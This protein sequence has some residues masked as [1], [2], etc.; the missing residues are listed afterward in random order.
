MEK[1]LL[2]AHEARIA[3]IV[4]GDY[5][6]LSRYVSDDLT[7]VSP[8]GQFQTKEEIYAGFLSGR[9]RQEK[10]D[11]SDTQVR[12]FGE[13]AVVSYRS[14]VRL[15]EGDKVTTGA[16]RAT[17]VYVLRPAGWQLVAMHQTKIEP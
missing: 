13:T 2:A 8:S 3:A 14:Q 16:L 17:G 10:M 12:I 5:E 1:E 9:V 7:Y 4:A 11:T 15:R 6:A